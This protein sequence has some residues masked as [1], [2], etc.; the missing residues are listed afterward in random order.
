M[1]EFLSR[2]ATDRPAGRSAAVRIGLDVGLRASGGHV[3]R[4]SFVLAVKS[5]GGQ[6][7]STL[8]RII[9]L[10][11]VSEFSIRVIICRS[12]TFLT[13]S[14]FAP[15]RNSRRACASRAGGGIA[16]PPYRALPATD[17]VRGAPIVT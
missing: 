14:A 10:R 13:R 9:A 11:S 17:I 4:S 12:K 8:S 6:Q 15:P 1:V 16:S 2:G 5:G 7:W 3:F